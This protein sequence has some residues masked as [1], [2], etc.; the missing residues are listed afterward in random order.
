M[1]SSS[2]PIRANGEV[3]G[4]V[5]VDIGM[6]QLEDYIQGLKIGEH[7]YAFLVTQSG[8]YAASP[9][10]DAN[11]KQ[12]ITESTDKDRRELGEKIMG[13]TEP[14]H[15]M[16]DAF[17]EEAYIVAMPIAS[18][19]L[20]LV[21]IAPTSD[22]SGPIH[23]AIVTNIIAALL[24]ILLLTGAIYVIFERRIAAPIQ[25]LLA[26]AEKIANGDLTAQVVAEH[27][28][29]LGHLATAISTMAEDIRKVM[30]KISSMSETLSAASE[31]LSSTAETNDIQEVSQSVESITREN[32]GVLAGT[33]KLRAIGDATASDAASITTS[34]QRQQD[35]QK[36]IASASQSL[37]QMAMDLQ[38]LLGHFSI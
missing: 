5:T 35:A 37:A 16:S 2:A 31:E 19:G 23:T 17:G 18:T 12:K 38:Q 21:L 3:V 9:D 29:E 22:Y 15:F 4:V 13:L 27:D 33:E 24:V 36:D 8:L 14:E 28:D 1:M 20:H 26:S 32:N 30:Q 25:H 6:K 10:A 34:V 11:M 7:G